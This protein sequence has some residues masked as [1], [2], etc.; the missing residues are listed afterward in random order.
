[1]FATVIAGSAKP[2]SRANHEAAV[3]KRESGCPNQALWLLLFPVPAL[4]VG[5]LTMQQ[6]GL[7]ASV[8]SQNSATWL[9]MCILCLLFIQSVALLQRRGVAAGVLAFSVAVIGGTFFF[10]GLHGVHRWVSLGPFLLQPAAIVIPLFLICTG[11]SPRSVVWIFAFT[12]VTL[13]ALQP[14]PASATA[15]LA[16]MV[17]RRAFGKE[18][19]SAFEWTATALL[20]ALVVFSWSRKDPLPQVQH[21]EGI[22]ALAR[23]INPAL[24]RGGLISLLVLP[25]PFVIC[26]R[27]PSCEKATSASLAAYFVVLELVCIT[28]RFPVPIMGYGASL[29]IGYVLALAW[30]ANELR[31]RR[32]MAR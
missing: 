18:R 31:A 28:G 24:A 16:G 5:A 22:L 27:A 6:S 7:N 4:L 21:V 17:V 13:L 20:L 23:S 10:A 11:S 26:A 32:R 14:D 9:L 8:W 25:L 12:T 3:S 29:V 2:D 1:M 15:L 30:L 19:V